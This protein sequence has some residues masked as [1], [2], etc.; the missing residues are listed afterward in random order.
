MLAQAYE[1]SGPPGLQDSFKRT[2]LASRS[3][4]SEYP[5]QGILF[6]SGGRPIATVGSPDLVKKMSLFA[7]RFEQ[8]ESPL[9]ED[10]IAGERI[11]G[12]SG[13]AYSV[14]LVFEPR[15]PL[16]L[17][18]KRF[19]M[20]EA[21]MIV[22]L[23]SGLFCYLITRHVTTPLFRLRTAAAKIAEGR[24]DTRVAASFGR[25]RDEIAQLGRDFDLMVERLEALLAGHKRLL[26]DVSHEL[27]SPLS[28]LV[29][30]LGLIKQGGAKD[31]AEHLERIAL[32]ANRLD[33]LIGQ[34][35]I[36]SRIDSGVQATANDRFDLTNLVHEVAADAEFE[37][38]ARGGKL[39]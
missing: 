20:V 25:R 33:R 14:V 21:P 13:A 31:L 24:L 9:V 27:R 32:E 18:S 10:G 29:V 39:P 36:L 37:A 19:F 7:A 11:T 34:L 22:L 1:D 30:A 8:T 12:A 3:L 6:R 16:A 38:R 17:T 2:L 35:L 4:S 5:I 26:G 15:T 23:A 28:R